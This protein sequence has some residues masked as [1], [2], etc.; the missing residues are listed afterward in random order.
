MT[1]R[2]RKIISECLL[3]Y[4]LLTQV[5]EWREAAWIFMTDFLFFRHS[6]AFAL[7]DP[8]LIT[9]RVPLQ[10]SS[11]FDTVLS[12]FT[13][14]HQISKR[15]HAFKEIRGCA[16]ENSA[17]RVLHRFIYIV[18]IHNKCCLKMV[19]MMCQMRKHL[20]MVAGRNL[21]QAEVQNW[22]F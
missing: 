16:A 5:D 1:V 4:A 8:S 2:D 21:Q 6:F 20:M 10:C 11:V 12:E 3:P 17:S 7:F 15:E 9:Q 13:Q 18:S 19:Y 22:K 14:S